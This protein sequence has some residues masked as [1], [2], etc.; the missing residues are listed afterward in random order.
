MGTVKAIQLNNCCRI[1]EVGTRKITPLIRSNS[2]DYSGTE[3]ENITADYLFESEVWETDPDD[4]NVW[5]Q[6]KLE[7]AEFGFE[8]TT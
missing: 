6:T 7:A 3:T 5:T 2:T 1:D 4:S 8:I